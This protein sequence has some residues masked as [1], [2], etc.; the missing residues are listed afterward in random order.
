MDALL[1]TGMEAKVSQGQRPVDLVQTG[2]GKELSTGNKRNNTLHL[3]IMCP[4]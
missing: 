2:L 3:S 1:D 4:A